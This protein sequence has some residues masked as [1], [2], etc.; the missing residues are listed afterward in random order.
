MIK[1][2]IEQINFILDNI[3]KGFLFISENLN[4]DRRKITRLLCKLKKYEIYPEYKKLIIDNKLQ[5][6]IK[7]IPIKK[8]GRCISKIDES[9][10]RKK[11]SLTANKNKKSGGM[12]KGS[13]VGKKGI[14]KGYWCDSSYELAWVIYNIDHNIKFERNYKSFPYEYNNKIHKYI[15][16][17]ILNKNYI[18]IKGYINDTTKCKIKN[19]PYVKI[20]MLNDLKTELDYVIS[21]YG[22]NFIDLY[23][24]KNFKLK[25]CKCGNILHRYNISGVCRKCIINNAK[26]PRKVNIKKPNVKKYFCNICNKKIRKNKTGLCKDCYKQPNKFEISKEKLIELINIY[27]YEKIAKMYNVSDRTVKK[28][29]I[30]FEIKIENRLGYWQKLKAQNKPKKYC[31]CGN[32]IKKKTSK[33]CV[34]CS[35]KKNLMYY[36]K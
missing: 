19:F 25:Y 22:K 6:K 17:F 18:E 33:I 10:R 29:I 16:D 14:Y 15:P 32:E 24:E 3:D 11:I 35:R 8:S 30:K 4:I 9:E 26:K 12:R 34:E 5:D 23:D 2:T 36:K 28:K 20:L 13:G 27:P 1:F 31:E 21:K 7:K